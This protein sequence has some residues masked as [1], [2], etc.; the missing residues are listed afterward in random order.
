MI[1]AVGSVA[2]SPSLG[3]RIADGSLNVIVGI[4]GCAIVLNCCFGERIGIDDRCAANGA[5]VS[6]AERFGPSF[7]IGIGARSLQIFD[8]LFDRRRRE[9]RASRFAN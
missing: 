5:A 4:V 3:R 8:E 9:C 6:D 1:G 2:P 7:D